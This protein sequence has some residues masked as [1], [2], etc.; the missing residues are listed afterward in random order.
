MEQPNQNFQGKLYLYIQY[1]IQRLDCCSIIFVPLY[2]CVLKCH[3][4]KLHAFLV[5]GLPNFLSNAV[6]SFNYVYLICR[7]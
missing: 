2:N 6:E 4:V 7:L 5:Y 3:H 1:L